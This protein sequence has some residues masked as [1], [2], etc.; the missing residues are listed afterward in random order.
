MQNVT[1]ADTIDSPPDWSDPANELACP[2][3]E[4]NLRG[5]IEPRCPEC[6]FSFRW[7]ELIDGQRNNNHYLFEHQNKRN[8]WSFWKT[9]WRDCRPRQFWTEVNPAQPVMLRRL[10]I[11][12]VLAC[13]VPFLVLEIPQTPNI[14]RL[15][16]FNNFQRS[17]FLATT[18]S[19]VGLALPPPKWVNTTYPLPWTF[20][21]FN[22]FW[23][24]TGPR[25]WDRNSIGPGVIVVLW[26]ILSLA[27]LM[28]FRVSMRQAKISVPHVLRCVLYGCDF[29][30]LIFV[31]SA[32][33][34][35]HEDWSHDDR[36]LAIITGVCTVVATYRIGFA[37]SRY[38]RFH[39][40]WA[41]VIASQAIVFLVLFIA[42][43][44]SEISF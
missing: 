30:T 14:W 33:G 38:L 42:C 5:L 6:G 23:A 17:F 11:Y 10:V 39:R 34:G 16:D 35:P 20:A 40:P 36:R 28:I 29:G 7:A 44:W 24:Q 8:I 31:V 4:Y 2:L 43:I 26:P 15:A 32:F 13:F 18:P 41:T 37:Y 27:T 3:C 19:T 22:E 25:S 12:W 9:Y 21:F 1:V